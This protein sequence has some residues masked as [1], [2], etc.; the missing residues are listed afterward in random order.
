MEISTI[1][2]SHKTHASLRCTASYPKNPE[3]QLR[4]KPCALTIAIETWKEYTPMTPYI[5]VV[6]L[7]LSKPLR[8]NTYER[9]K[10]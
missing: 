4:R 10:R 9:N 3:A 1:L 5:R 7:S 6:L 2:H 8:S